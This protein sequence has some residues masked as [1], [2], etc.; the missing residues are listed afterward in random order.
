M[1]TARV[2]SALP[3]IA[4]VT[5]AFCHRAARDRSQ[6]PPRGDVPTAST[7]VRESADSV[8]AAARARL[9]ARGYRIDA[10]DDLGRRLI[11][12]VPNDDVKVEVRVVAK[13]DGS[14][15][16]AAPLGHRGLA[17]GLRA[18]LAVMHAATAEGTAEPDGQ[19]DSGGRLGSR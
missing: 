19:A 13:G 15:I 5:L 14:A 9:A 4:L 12:R 7:T 18:V 2:R 11:V 17:A 3:L 1:P 8:Y 6:P 16:T 10:A